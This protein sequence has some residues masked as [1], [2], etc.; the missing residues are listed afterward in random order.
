MSLRSSASPSPLKP[1]LCD[2]D[3]EAA[4]PEWRPLLLVGK[5]DR[6]PTVS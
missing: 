6:V 4:V 1:A 3:G 5:L 2:L